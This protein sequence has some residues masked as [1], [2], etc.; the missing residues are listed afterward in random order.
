MPQVWRLLR[1][2]WDE[3]RVSQS[4]CSRYV[5]T[6]LFLAMTPNYSVLQKYS[7]TTGNPLYVMQNVIE[8]GKGNSVC[9]CLSVFCQ[10]CYL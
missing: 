3:E 1:T 6:L 2:A 8:G 7:K 4:K 10:I 9:V 5:S